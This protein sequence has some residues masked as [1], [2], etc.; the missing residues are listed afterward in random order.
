[1]RSAALTAENG[2]TAQSSAQAVA[3]QS[4]LVRPKRARIAVKQE[5]EEVSLVPGHFQKQTE[6]V[7]IAIFVRTPSLTRV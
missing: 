1:M 2:S 6:T 4:S 3:E 5:A 7:S